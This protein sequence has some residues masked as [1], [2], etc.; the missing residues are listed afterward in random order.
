M[1]TQTITPNPRPFIG[2]MF[3]ISAAFAFS[4]KAVII[5]IAYG[6]GAH[7]T[8]LMLMTLRMLFALPFFVIA[9]FLIERKNSYTALTPKDKLHLVGL[10]VIG[11]YLA[12]YFDFLGLHYISASLERLVLLLYPT[13]VVVL[14][15]IFLKHKITARE[16]IA[17]AVS[18]IGI[19]TV[20]YE[21]L[22]IAGTDVVLGSALI[23][24]SATAFAIYLIGSGQMVKRVGAMRFTAYAMTI[25]CVTTLIHFGIEFDATVATLPIEVYGLAL[26]MAI[27]STVIPTF[28]MNAGIQHLGAGP[29]S[30]ISSLGPVMTIFLAYLILDEQL[31]LIQ[32]AGATLVISGVFVVNSKKK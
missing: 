9:I 29:A 31:S 12:A 17:L 5:K 4:A 3:V 20:F 13:L 32:M 26:L 6:Y 27:I 10:G 15:A 21:E 16:A 14:S 18:Y 7:I 28:L 23:L 22:S 11:F 8:P 25:A 2:L 24:A 30:I 19:V 1:S